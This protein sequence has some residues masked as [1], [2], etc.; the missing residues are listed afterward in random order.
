MPNLGVSETESVSLKLTVETPCAGGG[1]KQITAN[2]D[3]QNTVYAF[4]EAELTAPVTQREMVLAFCRYRYAKG[5]A[6]LNV[7]II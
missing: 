5:K 7:R 3:G 4:S 1:H 6:S 2:E